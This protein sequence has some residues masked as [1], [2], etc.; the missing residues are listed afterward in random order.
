M[1]NFILIANPE[2]RRV[3]FLQQ[4]LTHLNLP[5]ATVIDYADLISGKQTLEQF[6]APNTIIRFDSPEKNFDIDK[7]IIAAGF[8]VS[9]NGQHQSISPG[10]AMELEFDKGRIL[11][12]RQWYLGWRYLLQKW[13]TLFTPLLACGEG[14]GVGYFM[15]HPQDIAVMF[16]KPACHER[17][18]RN[19][20]PVPRSLGKIH[21]Y[22]H[23]REQMQTQGIERVFVKLS[24]GSAASGVV[25]YRANS[26]FESAITTVERVRENGE[27][28]LYNSRKISHYT[29][30]E[31]IADIINIL[32]AEGVQVEEWL[33]K[34]HLQGCGFDVRVVVINGKAQHIVVRLGKSPMTNLHLGNE[35]GDT[36]EFLAKV[37]AENWE[38]MKRTCEQAAS[39]FPNSL[40]CGVDLLILPDWKTHAILEINAF[41]DLL[42][43]IL[44]NG[45][46]TYT[47][48]VKAILERTAEAQRTQTMKKNF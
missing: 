4:A 7:A 10:E 3:G 35:R 22:E 17:F 44:W 33:P 24:H 46:D 13:E 6:N 1:L 2:N 26:R 25:A 5:P 19:N 37:G 16:D 18:S 32:T 41:G 23:L 39:L 47:S 12:P 31:E 15:N 11:Y 36:E 9:D 29:R 48:E 20:I 30:R 42:P 38:M 34:A 8:N 21:N 43:G 27:T 28:L 14:L 45:I 40:Y